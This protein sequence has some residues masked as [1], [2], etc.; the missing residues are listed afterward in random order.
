MNASA[1]RSGVD[2]RI[3]LIGVIVLLLAA[4]GVAAWAYTTN[5]TLNATRATLDST[6]ADLASTKSSLTGTEADLAEA[7]TDLG[8]EQDAIEANTAKLEV[9][10]FQIS[11]KDACI[12][13]QTA[14]LAEIRRILELERSNGGRTTTGSTWYKAHAT[15]DKA[16]DLA[17]SYMAKAYT[18]AAAGN[19]STANSWLSKSNAQVKTS[20]NQ[21]KVMNR[22]IDA[23]NALVEQ[24][25]AA[26][27]EFGKTLIRTSST[28]GN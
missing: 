10:E 8:A 13:A 28:C 7:R 16:L 15:S 21:I 27:V 26:S 6:R 23:F 5:E 19:Y 9:L 12:E 25:N 1:R 4:G 24:I 22:E 3:V 20:N 18:S 17:I 14:N 11:R 2:L